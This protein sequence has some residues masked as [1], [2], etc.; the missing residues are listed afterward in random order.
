[1]AAERDE[2]EARTGIRLEVARVAVRSLSKERGVEL[3]AEV[4]TTDAAS[5]VADPTID[6][7]V[8]VLGGIEPA[9]ELI[10][11]ALKAGKPVVTANKELLANVG[12]DLFAVAETAGV[13]LLFEAAVAGGH[14][15]HPPAARVARRRAGASGDRHRQR[16]DQLHPQPDGRAS[17]TSYHDAL[18]EA[19]SLGL[20]R[21]RSDR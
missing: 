16:H 5:I 19:Q 14:P 9:R 7:V 3:P 10:T 17:G 15:V 6:L 18:A 13:D 8:E 1:M 21:T 2:I 12:A 20:R 4:F 11:E